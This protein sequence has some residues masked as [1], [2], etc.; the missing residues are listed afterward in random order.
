MNREPINQSGH[1]LINVYNNRETK[2]F[3]EENYENLYIRKFLFCLT[4]DL[5][6]SKKPEIKAKTI[7]KKYK[8]HITESLFSTYLLAQ[9]PNEPIDEI[10]DLVLD[11]LGY[12]FSL[13]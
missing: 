6:T 2:E 3:Y 11:F 12:I 7:Y 1:V 4:E 13:S 10:S 8:K 9:D 5:Y